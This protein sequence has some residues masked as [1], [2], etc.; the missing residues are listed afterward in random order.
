MTNA[1]HSCQEAK[2]I[3]VTSELGRSPKQWCHVRTLLPCNKAGAH[4]LVRQVLRSWRCHSSEEG[5]GKAEMHPKWILESLL[6]SE[7]P[8]WPGK[9]ATLSSMKSI[10]KKMWAWTFVS[11]WPT[12][13]WAS[14]LSLCT[15]RLLSFS[16]V[17]LCDPMDCS[18][19]GFPVLHYTLE[20]AQTHG[21]IMSQWCHPT[22]SSSA[23]LFSF[24]FQSP[25]TRV[26]SNESALCI[27]WPK[28][29]HFSF[30]ICP[31]N[32]YSGLISFR[33]DWLD[34]LAVQGTLKSLLQHHN[35][36]ASILQG[37]G[38][39]D[40]IICSELHKA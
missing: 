1:V 6:P 27:R 28:Y 19:P 9:T 32:E 35:S 22:I 17:R 3:K 33:M 31:S 40:H 7:K 8:G 10:P 14:C 39:K 25:S 29:W 2:A 24:W 26:F 4:F 5:G 16:C 20:F 18:T 36:K 34:L 15:A 38:L 37:S 23:T 30:R 13:P 12:S 11:L 21:I